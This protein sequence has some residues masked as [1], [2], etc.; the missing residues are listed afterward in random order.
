MSAPYAELSPELVLDAV[1][2]AGQRTD[3]RL[4]ALNS[5]ENRVYQLGLEEAGFVV[6]KFYRPERWSDAAILE[7]HAFAAE[8]V[9][10]EIPVVPPMVLADGSTLA[11]HR[12]FRFALFERRGGRSPELE[13]PAVLEW[14]GR[15]LGRLHVVGARRPF[16]DRPMLSVTSFGHEPREF[17]LASPLLPEEFREAYAAVSARLIDQ[18]QLAFDGVGAIATLRLH[19][20]CHNG[21]I[22]WTDLGPHFVDLDDALHELEERMAQPAT[23]RASRAEEQTLARLRITPTTAAVMPVSGA[24]NFRSPWVDSTS[25]PP[26]RM[27]RK[28]QEGEPGHQ[29][30]RQAPARKAVGPNRLSVV[31]PRRRRR[32]PPP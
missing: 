23:A 9:E 8:L 27:N 11:E 30:G 12:G 22:L 21:N 14:I 10:S 29:R 3:G 32:R 28:R 7:E 4:H 19:G 15:F 18:L 31:Q 24:V 26:S 13:D 16:A 2:A 6:A 5:Y 20:D 17:V 25:G 1:D